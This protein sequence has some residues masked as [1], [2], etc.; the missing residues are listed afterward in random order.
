MVSFGVE[1][2]GVAMK[3]GQEAAEEV[4]KHFVK[5]I[6]LEFEKV[7][8]CVPHVVLLGGLANPWGRAQHAVLCSPLLA[9]H[10]L[11]HVVVL[12]RE[13]AAGDHAEGTRSGGSC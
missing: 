6:K 7:S 11:P 3:L 4:S 13:H 12:P 2:I 5:P 9:A 8:E 10:L 1:D